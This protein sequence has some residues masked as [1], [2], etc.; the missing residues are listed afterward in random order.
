MNNYIKGKYKKAIFNSDNGYIIGLFKVKETDQ[1][2]VKDYLDKTL[3]FTGYFADLNENDDYIFYGE[4][5][6]HPRYGYQY[7]VKEYEKIKPQDN[8]GIIA[9]LSSDIFPGIGEKMAT[10]IVEVLGNDAIDKILED[11]SCLNLVPKLSY[12][13][14]KNLK[15]ILEKHEQSNK[16]MVYLTDLGFSMQD[17]LCIYNKY[18]S[19]TI[20][21]IEHDIFSLIDDIDSINFS[22][23][24][25]ISKKLGVLNDDKRR[26]KACFT[27][28]MEVLTFK[29]G[30]TY[31]T[32]EEVKK[33]L[34]DYLR[35]NINDELLKLYIDEL[36]LERKIVLKDDQLYLK[37]IFDA[38]ENIINSISKLINKKIKD[39]KKIDKH[40]ENLEKERQIIY[41]DKQKEAIKNALNNNILIITGGPGTGKTTI[42]QAIVEIYREINNLNHDKLIN[43]IALLAPTGRASKRMSEATNL[44]A[45]TIHRFLKWNKE[46]NEFMIN[47]YNKDFSELII[48]D[49]VSMIDINLFSSLF[50]GI[51]SNVKLILVGDYNQL[52]SVGPGNLLKDLITSKVIDTV[53]LDLLYR[54]DENSYINMLAHDVKNGNLDINFLETK[55]DYAFLNCS[56]NN[57]LNSLK[58]TCEKLIKKDIDQKKVQIMAPM[59][60][61]INGI[62]N[63]NKELQTLF[64]PKDDS[65]NEIKYGN[66]VFRENDKILQLVNM[67]DDN[68]FN[69]DVGYIKY[70]IK[71]GSSK[72]KKN[73]IYVD[74]DGNIVKYLPKDFNKIKHGFIIS[75]HKSQGS[76][77][78]LVIIPICMSYNRMLYR[79]LIYTAITRAKKKLIIIG[80][81][82]AFEY[83]VNN[84]NEYVRKTNLCQKLKKIMYNE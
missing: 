24:D 84:N 43:Q 64:N 44:P 53:Y 59:Y 50:K 23:I 25:N 29:K 66:V 1:E 46:N 19:N 11:D 28:I 17:S 70:I 75:I 67:P 57:I 62:D 18:K 42:I 81:P 68:V 36:R 79:K 61:G 56:S 83:S 40:I 30:D 12:K 48:I 4:L 31:L 20:S 34:I 14:A 51:T 39:N 13:K 35:I 77:F 58:L 80:Q 22:K 54:Q 49:E 32:Y 60:A 52:P 9:F 3:T 37:D 21:N 10:R 26:I 45:T 7:Q 15:T 6:N 63:L 38:E 27:Y 16:I 73:E 2:D 74:Y 65:K 78:D 82:K 71:A 69:G 41:N 33:H 5:I 55:N 8:E 72:S 47:E 76:E